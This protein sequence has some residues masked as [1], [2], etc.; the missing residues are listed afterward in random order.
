MATQ[1]RQGEVSLH[2]SDENQTLKAQPKPFWLGKNLEKKSP[3]DSHPS[4]FSAELYLFKV[5][6]QKHKVD[7]AESQLSDDEEKVHH[8]PAEGIRGTQR[9]SDSKASREMNICP[10]H[11]S[12]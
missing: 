8:M 6:S 10:H 2:H 1:A 12:G 5:V 7:A 9:A 11:P 3:F 4:Y